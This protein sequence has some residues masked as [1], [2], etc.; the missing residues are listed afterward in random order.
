MNELK[1]QQRVF[2]DTLLSRHQDARLLD[3]C[4]YN[5]GKLRNVRCS[6]CIQGEIL[7]RQCWL[8]KHRTMPT[9]WALVWN[10]DERFYEKTDFCRVMGG[11]SVGLGHNGDQC[12][13]APPARSFTLVDCNGIHATAMSFCGCTD[14]GP[15]FQQL[16]RAGIFPGTTKEPKTGYT[17]SLLEY[18]RELRNQDKG[19]AYDFVIILQRLAD[20]MFAGLVPDIRKNFLVISRFH[21]YLDILLR[22]GYGHGMDNVLPGESDRPYPNRPKGFLGTICPACLERGVNMPLV[23]D[24]PRYLSH[25]VAEFLTLNGNYKANLFFKR[26]DGS[27]EALTD[28]DMY[29]PKQTDFQE[30]AKSLVVTEEDK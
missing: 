8:D 3:P 20:P 10:K 1:A 23:V 2:I 28:G 24:I 7:C 13:K 29:F 9:H 25:L 18:Y 26:D 17:L 12:E 16:L 4:S 14:A 30:F 22:R 11:A 21:Q 19:S 6:D 5:S 15:E 27:D